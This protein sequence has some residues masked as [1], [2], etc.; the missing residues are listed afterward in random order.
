[1]DGKNSC[2]PVQNVFPADLPGKVQLFGRA[3]DLAIERRGSSQ[4]Q[5][6]R[7]FL[8][9]LSP[10][11]GRSPE[12]CHEQINFAQIVGLRFDSDARLLAHGSIENH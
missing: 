1:M 5:Q 12:G 6:F 7:R 10:G 2:A 11:A 3:L 8:S 4:T 9:R